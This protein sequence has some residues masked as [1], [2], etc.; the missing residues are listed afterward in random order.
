[1]FKFKGLGATLP[2]PIPANE[3]AAPWETRATSMIPTVRYIV[4]FT[5]LPCSPLLPRSEHFQN[6]ARQIGHRLY[7]KESTNFVFFCCGCNA[8]IGAAC[9]PL[10]RGRPLDLFHAWAHARVS[11]SQRRRGEVDA[12]LN[13]S[14]R[15]AS[16]LRDRA[17]LSLL[18]SLSLKLF[19]SPVQHPF[20][21]P[22]TPLRPTGSATCIHTSTIA[23]VAGSIATNS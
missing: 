5:A 20:M 23:Y 3:N 17:A 7:V 2:I 15:R 16:L 14:G 10:T 12:A 6:T 13:A 18:L 11:V 19:S 9:T 8:H 1:M 4:R 21:N 22:F